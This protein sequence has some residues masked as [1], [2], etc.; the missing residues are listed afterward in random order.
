MLIWGSSFIAMKLALQAYDPLLIVFGR[1]IIASCIFLFFY[2]K[3]RQTLYHK[4]DWKYLVLMSLFEPCFY[5]IF[6]AYA[7]TYTTASQA[8]MVTA[9]LPL[10]VAISAGVL[11]KEKITPTVLFGF[12]TACAGIGI[13][14][15]D[16][17]STIDAPNPILGNFLELLAMICAAGYT[18]LARHLGARYSAL[19]LT[20]FQMLIG[21]FFFAPVLIFPSTIYPTAF[22]IVPSF[23]LAY[24][25][26]IVSFGAYGLYNHALRTISA[27]HASAYVNLIPVFTAFLGWLILD[28]HFTML[29]SLG[30]ILVLAGVWISTSAFRIGKLRADSA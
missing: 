6:E 7:L 9:L 8:G 19:F 29:Q 12:F 30:A 14:S 16:N 17:S 20:A 28:E 25:G 11:L 24:L 23:A 21:A 26:T 1:M 27:S 2:K 10:L 15:F 18:I 4:G 22:P 3:L 13:L 5:F